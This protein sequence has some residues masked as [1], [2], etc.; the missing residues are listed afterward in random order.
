LKIVEGPADTIKL[1]F[2]KL[3]SILCEQLGEPITADAI[4]DSSAP[5]FEGEASM[6]GPLQSGRPEACPDPFDGVA[7][8][9]T[10]KCLCLPQ[11][12]PEHYW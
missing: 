1:P 6:R 10:K 8:L 11:I 12:K 4:I 9:G 2:K 7:T 3:N 5:S